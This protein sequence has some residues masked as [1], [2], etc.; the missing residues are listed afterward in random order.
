M[1]LAFLV[2]LGACVWCLGVKSESEKKKK[3]KKK[4][5]FR[6]ALTTKHNIIIIIIIIISILSVELFRETIN[7]YNNNMYAK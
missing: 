7:E 4:K 5:A 1:T 2:V 6:A 3:K